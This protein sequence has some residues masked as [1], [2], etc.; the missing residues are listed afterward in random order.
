[1]SF[2]PS[3][4]ESESEKGEDPKPQQH[5][6]KMV[7]HTRF[8]KSNNEQPPL[9]SAE[10]QFTRSSNSP[11]LMPAVVKDPNIRIEFAFDCRSV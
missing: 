1:M 8:N 5:I 9:L 3:G 7:S 2:E 11:R 6:I 4:A 10:T